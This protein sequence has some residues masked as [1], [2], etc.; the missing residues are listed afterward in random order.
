MQLPPE[1]AFLSPFFVEPSETYRTAVWL[2]SD[3]DEQVWEY[4]F[5]YKEPKEGLK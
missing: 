2:R 1:L 3:F 4:S 5:D